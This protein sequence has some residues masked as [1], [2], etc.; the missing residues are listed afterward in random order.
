[1]KRGMLGSEGMFTT[2]ELYQ[3]G[4]SGIDED[5]VRGILEIL[6]DYRYVR[7]AEKDAA[8]RNGRPSEMWQINPRIYGNDLGRNLQNPQNPVLQVL[9]VPP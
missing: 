4:W 1:M 3:K 8:A 7:L 2:R 5:T 6:E 9:Q